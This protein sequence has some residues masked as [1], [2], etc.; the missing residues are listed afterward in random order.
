MANIALSVDGDVITRARACAQTRHTM[1]NQRIRD[2]LHRLTGYLD[3]AASD[4]ARC[5]LLWS[6]DLNFGQLYA[7]LRV[8]N[9]FASTG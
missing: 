4:F 7:S 5:G 2:Y 9:P 8:E 6:E 3:P 1:L